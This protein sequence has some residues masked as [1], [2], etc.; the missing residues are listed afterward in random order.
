M[1][2]A[3][4]RGSR[5]LT[6]AAAHISILWSVPFASLSSP[7]VILTSPPDGGSGLQLAHQQL[8]LFIS[9]KPSTLQPGSVWRA[10][11]WELITKTGFCVAVQTSMGLLVVCL[12]A[13][14]SSLRVQ[15]V[16]FAAFL[17]RCRVSICDV[18]DFRGLF[19]G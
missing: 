4:G 15:Y 16:I 18:A 19:P 7:W 11:G 1:R 12:Y 5:A 13:L 17:S 10:G 9:T 14:S 8:K 2:T 3:P 6:M